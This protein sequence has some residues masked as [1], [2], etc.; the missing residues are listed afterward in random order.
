MNKLGTTDINISAGF[1]IQRPLVTS[2]P[3]SNYLF[4]LAS[5]PEICATCPTLPF[6]R[7]ISKA[8]KCCSETG[9]NW[10]SIQSA[11]FPA[12]Q[13]WPVSPA[14]NLNVHYR[15]DSHVRICNEKLQAVCTCIA[16]YRHSHCA[17]MPSVSRLS[18]LDSQPNGL[19]PSFFS[20]E[21]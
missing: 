7:L 5:G 19:Q 8:Q 15:R 14:C 17:Q 10:Q 2:I 4:R 6:I 11:L 18:V 21:I 16:A 13:H 12:W 20:L 1:K 3:A 9:E